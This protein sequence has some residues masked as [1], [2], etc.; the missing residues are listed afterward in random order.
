MQIDAYRES[1]QFFN[2]RVELY[3]EKAISRTELRAQTLGETPEEAETAINAIEDSSADDGLNQLISSL[4][5]VQ[6]PQDG[7]E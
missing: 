1:D 5:P 6:P 2:Q 4:S 3:S 7:E